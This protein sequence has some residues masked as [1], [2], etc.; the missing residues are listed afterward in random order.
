M[1]WG[2]SV[3]LTA[4]SEIGIDL[5]MFIIIIITYDDDDDDDAAFNMQ[6]IRKIAS[7][8]CTY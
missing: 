4:Q 3:L 2:C 6:R 8:L 1:K 7:R 5:L